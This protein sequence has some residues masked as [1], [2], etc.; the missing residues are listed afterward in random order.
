MRARR[1]APCALCPG[2][3]IKHVAAV[4]EARTAFVTEGPSALRHDLPDGVTWAD[5]AAGTAREVPRWAIEHRNDF[6][7]L[8]GDTL[9]GVLACYERVAARSEEIVASVPDLSATH[10]LPEAPGTSREPCAARAG[11]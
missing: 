3:L 7:T 6:R 5:L 11:C 9:D 4:E 2:G 8:P 1:P 10:P